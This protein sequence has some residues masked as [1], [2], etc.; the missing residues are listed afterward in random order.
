MA[1]AAHRRLWA[2][3]ATVALGGFLFGY[4]TGVASG[5]LLYLRGDL[6]ALGRSR[7]GRGRCSRAA[8]AS[9]LHGLCLAAAW[10]CA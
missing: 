3:A 10:A 7:C 6:P 1:S 5:A 4:D 8:G 2:L 9:P